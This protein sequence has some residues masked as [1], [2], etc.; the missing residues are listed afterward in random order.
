MV[1]V[2]VGDEL[3]SLIKQ[4]KKYCQITYHK[5][6]PEVLERF[7]DINDKKIDFFLKKK[8]IRLYSHQKKAISNIL[9]GKNVCVATP[10][11]SGKTLCY[12]IPIINSLINDKNSKSLLIYPLKALAQDQKKKL[13]ESLELISPFYSCDIY[14]GDTK[15]G[16]RDKIK[17]NI[18]S[19][20]MTNPDMLHYGLLPH[21]YLW[22]D[23]FSNLKYVV[24]D[25]V[26]TYRGI[27]G[28]NVSWI[29]RRLKRIAKFYG[30]SPKIIATSA[31]V[32]NPQ[33]FLFNLF[34]ENFEIITER[35]D[36]SSERHF[37]I[38]NP[39]ED[40]SAYKL[41]GRIFTESIKLNLRTIVFTKARKITELIYSFFN[42]SSNKLAKKV[43]SYRAGY[44]PEERREIEKK[45]FEGSL[46]GVISTSA[47]ELGI[48][49]GN[50]DVCIL[51]GYPGSIINTLQRAGRVGRG[52]RPSLTVLIAQR[53]ALDQFF[54]KNPENFF[55][56]G[57]ESIVIDN[58]NSIISKNHILC[59][60]FELPLRAEEII[61][62]EE[63]V[64]DLIN[65]GRL[66]SSEDN[67][68]FFSVEKNP[69]RKVNIRDSGE[70][71]NIV[72][73]KNRQV[74]ATIS[75][76]RAFSECHSGAIYLHKGTNYYVREI[77]LVKKEVYVSE[78]NDNFYTVPLISKD[79]EILSLEK[80]IN[81]NNYNL[82][83]GRLR[84]TE[85]VV[86]FERKDIFSQNLLSR[87][88][89]D[90]PPY[91]F[92]TEGIIISISKD[93]HTSL[94][95]KDYHLMGSLHAVEHAMI[96]LMPT[97]ILC[98][99]QDI[100]GICYPYHYQL[101]G[102]GIFIYDGYDGGI[103]LTQKAFINFNKLLEDTLELVS[104]CDCDL[105]CPS[106]IHSPKCGS[107][108]Y[109]L[110]KEGA[111]Y[112]L[113]ILKSDKEKK[114]EIKN[115]KP[116][117]DIVIEKKEDIFDKSP[118][119]FDL[120]TKRLA[121][122]VGGWQNSHL[123]G[124]SLGVIYDEKLGEFEFY[125]EREVDKLIDRLEK[126][127]LVVGF[128]TEDFDYKVL[129]PYAGRKLKINSF[130]ILKKIKEKTGKRKSLSSLAKINLGDIKIGDGLSAV[131]WFREGDI[132]RL[133]EYCKKDV[134]LLYKLYDFIRKKGYILIEINE[135]ITKL[136]IP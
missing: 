20:L 119:Y 110:D 77:D 27:F 42:R 83:F 63:E 49:V 3:N 81:G 132:E 105:G 13:T 33:E 69:H 56:R 60:A 29:F 52:R 30:S 100:G 90:L 28:A 57:V 86:G 126:A 114:V 129:T 124:L 16:K 96:G 80:E 102:A 109:P 111:K 40:E 43:S 116:F 70:T 15:Q 72:D 127:E 34:Q 121:D 65:R 47:L 103:G 74:I 1:D 71:Y 66:V 55:Q 117:I 59:S 130:D 88:E 31:T 6:Y 73:I 32:G 41:A 8:S 62:Y 113:S 104:Q 36:Y 75:G 22:E 38:I 123:M 84:V 94:K 4:V 35:G 67:R 85:R 135:R 23:L 11:A 61:S 46:L 68:I 10:T 64:R 37:I 87:E 79:T 98:D 136:T 99:R 78:S 125:E 53:D 7:E 9:E 17:R 44:L 5:T 48:D 133:R 128:N 118:I 107:Q 91:T 58:K 95:E 39:D 24:V 101:K 82:Y 134:E 18:P 131:K 89:L 26:H 51:V 45:L 92:E 76:R 14:D 115:E 106:C 19:C 122:E 112:L 93:I 120:E 2:G 97:I 12:H 108:N 25:E 21:H 50:L 54:V